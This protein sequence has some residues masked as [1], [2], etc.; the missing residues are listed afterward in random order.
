MA[1]SV[2]SL[3][4]SEQW[5]GKGIRQET[6]GNWRSTTR[7]RGSPHTPQSAHR[8]QFRESPR[9]NRHVILNGR[10][11]GDVKP[12]GSLLDWLWRSSYGE[13]IPR[14]CNAQA[15]CLARRPLGL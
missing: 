2:R 6:S 3:E 8:S 9:D 5:L 13:T 7:F 10:D 11:V 15:T 14:R 12:L 1:M 4:N